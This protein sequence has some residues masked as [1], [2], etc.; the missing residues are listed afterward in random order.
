MGIFKN[1]KD[2]YSIEKKRVIFFLFKLRCSETTTRRTRIRTM[3]RVRRP[4][5]A[6]WREMDLNGEKMKQ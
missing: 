4:E 2:K 5:K 6:N 3:G 1:N